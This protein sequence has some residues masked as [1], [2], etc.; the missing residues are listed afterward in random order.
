MKKYYVI[1]QHILLGAF[2]LIC[3]VNPCWKR[4]MNVRNAARKMCRPNF[5]YSSYRDKY[6]RNLYYIYCIDKYDYV[7][8]LQLVIPKNKYR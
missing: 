5:F 1:L 3:F 7:Y 8:E 6:N 2:V 4:S